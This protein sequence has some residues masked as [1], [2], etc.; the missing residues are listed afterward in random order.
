MKKALLVLLAL[1][2]IATASIYYKSQRD[3]SLAPSRQQQTLLSQILEFPKVEVATTS[4]KTYTMA[5]VEAHGLDP[6]SEECWTVIHG[7]VY[8]ILDF[9]SNSHPGGEFIFQACGI[10]ATELF[11]T[12]S[13]GSKTPHSA[14]ARKILEKY[15]IGDLKK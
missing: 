12:R 11:E 1:I 7:K 6:D 5:E 15:Y 2:I 4:P 13:M 10:D 14:E 8:N 9:A 3:K